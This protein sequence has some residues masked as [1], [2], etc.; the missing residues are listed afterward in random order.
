MAAF[1]SLALE[2]VLAWRALKASD[3]EVP[4]S[5]QG[6]SQLKYRNSRDRTNIQIYR[7]QSS[8]ED[9]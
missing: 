6:P 9:A 5:L 8:C 1:S 2:V 4:K 7:L 3:C